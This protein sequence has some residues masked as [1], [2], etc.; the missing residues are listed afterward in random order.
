[1]I[2]E[3]LFNE[4]ADRERN[5]HLVLLAATKRLYLQLKERDCF[6]KR[7][8]LGLPDRRIREGILR[9][10]TKDMKLETNVNLGQL[11]R[12]TPGFN[13]HDLV[14]V[15]KQ[16]SQ[17]AAREKRLVV[18]M[19]DFENGLERVLLSTAN[20]LLLD[21]SLRLVMAYH[22]AGHVLATWSSPLA[23]PIQQISILQHEYNHGISNHHTGGQTKNYSHQYLLSFLR[24]MLAGRAAE[25]IVLGEATT[26][27]EPDLGQA[28]RIAR[29]MVSRWGMG[30]FSFHAPLAEVRKPE[31]G[32]LTIRHDYS[33]ETAAQID[34]GIHD[35]LDIQYKAN[36]KLMKD[37]RQSLDRL[38]HALLDE[39]ILTGEGIEK[40]LG[41]RTSSVIPE[42]TYVEVSNNVSNE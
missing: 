11:A 22:Q 35:L 37:A 12:S 32:K 21:E 4:L 42:L 10:H 9:I 13:G 14:M 7:I 28:N 16:A 15:C 18:G 1:V 26:L 41:P 40:I 6:E 8:T 19:A 38:A 20:P 23:E 29:H 3:C 5:Q 25:V 31:R 34:Q 30:K 24:V 39:E 17:L 36:L 2:Y 27:A 33:E